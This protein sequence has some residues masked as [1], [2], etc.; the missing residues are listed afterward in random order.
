MDLPTTAIGKSA[1]RTASTQ[2]RS[3]RSTFLK[4]L[5]NVHGWI[6]LWG[7]VLGLMFGVTGFLLNH[8]GGPMKISPGEP[9]VSQMRL[10][11]PNP[12]PD[13]PQ[14]LAEW[15]GR[16]LRFDGRIGRTQR[17]PAHKVA[18]G[19]RSVMQPEHWSA[20]LAGPKTSILIEYWQGNPTVSVK[21]TEGTLLAMLNN[22]HRGGGMGRGWT[23]LVDTIAGSLVLLSLTGVLLWTELNRR[24]TIGAAIFAVS[25]VAMV[26][27]GIV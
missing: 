9:Q 21:R 17:E 18:W 13:S 2:S 11:L 15:V 16:E 12:A 8:R 19:D 3:R 14:A 10:P 7:A 5:R 20:M 27:C 22:M 23:L 24:K 4:W 6:G 1:S 25:L 26:V